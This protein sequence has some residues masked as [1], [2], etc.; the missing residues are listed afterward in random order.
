LPKLDSITAEVPTSY[1]SLDA[2][3]NESRV[4]NRSLSR[5]ILLGE[6]T[7][8]SEDLRAIQEF[9]E[10]SFISQVSWVSVEELMLGQ[11]G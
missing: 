5:I 2:I 8:D 6:G 3:S 11:T 4:Q 10:L 7:I 9:V 1:D